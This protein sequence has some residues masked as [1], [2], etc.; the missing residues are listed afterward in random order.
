MNPVT[1]LP[2]IKGKRV[3]G[4]TTKGEEEEGVLDTIKS[5]NRP[6]IENTAKDCGA[7]YVS[8]PGPWDSFTVTDDRVVTGANPA[9]AHATAVAAVEAFKNLDNHDPKIQ[10]R[11]ETV[12]QDFPEGRA[13]R[14]N[15]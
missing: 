12:A 10:G 1:T 15:E 2:V 13:G 14:G 9:S 11:K 6:T 3:T 7:T 5:W 8:P 4:F